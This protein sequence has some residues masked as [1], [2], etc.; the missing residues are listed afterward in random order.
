GPIPRRDVPPSKKPLELPEPGLRQ[1]TVHVATQ[2]PSL[3]YGFNVPSLST[4]TDPQSVNALRLISALLDG[5]YSARRTRACAC[6]GHRR[7]GVRTRF[8]HQ[9]GQHH[10]R[11]G[12]RWPV[13]AAHRPGTG[14]AAERNAARHPE[15]CT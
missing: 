13:L 14:G 8:D 6:P 1:I 2:M 11:T 7:A 12:N 5:G 4:A 3:M 9:S 10:R 15:S